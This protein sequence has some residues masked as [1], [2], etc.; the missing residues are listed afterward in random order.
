MISPWIGGNVS[1]VASAVDKDVFDVISS[2]P[3]ESIFSM[4]YVAALIRITARNVP[5][6]TLKIV[7][8]LFCFFLVLQN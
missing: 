8:N 3:N 6:N 2:L 5:A 1:I 4:L 7:V